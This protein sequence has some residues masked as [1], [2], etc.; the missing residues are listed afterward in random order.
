MADGGSDLGREGSEVGDDGVDLGREGIDLGDERG[1]P[2][3]E[4][5]GRFVYRNIFGS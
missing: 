2:A 5:S 1:D 4:T 3:F